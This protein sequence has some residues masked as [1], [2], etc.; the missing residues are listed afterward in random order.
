MFSFRPSFKMVFF[1]RSVIRTNWKKINARPLQRAGA[2]VRKIAR[3]SIKRDRRRKVFRSGKRGAYGQPSKPG[4]PP[5]SRDAAR[6]FKLIFNMPY[7]FGTTEIVG[8]VGFG[9]RDPAPGMS[10]H[11]GFARR[12]VFMKG[13][14]MVKVVRS[15]KYKKR[16]FMLPALYKGKSSMPELWRNSLG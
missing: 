10:E 2:L 16:P 14:S 9:Q 6:S 7:R 4:T 15:V 5:F 8:M 12:R 1:D 11:G 13:K 3:Q